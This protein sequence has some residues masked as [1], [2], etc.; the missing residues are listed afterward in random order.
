L[1][2][3]PDAREL[4]KARIQ[5]HYLAH[6]CFTDAARLLAT[7][8]ALRQ[9]PAAIVHGAEDPV[10]PP[11]TARALH[12]AWPAADYVEVAGAGHS[13]LDAAIAAACV[14]ALD[15][16]AER[17]HPGDRPRRSR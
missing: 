11:A 9:L 10:C 8:A 1:A 2:T 16:V 12:H 7:C 13:G 14:A 17:A 4:A 3:P 5:A 15:R 6:G